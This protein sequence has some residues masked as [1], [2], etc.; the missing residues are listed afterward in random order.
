ML[1]TVHSLMGDDAQA[2]VNYR[3]AIEL[4]P[5]AR[6]YS[7][8]G[9]TYYRQ[10]RFAEAAPAYEQAARL[11]PSSPIKFRNLGDVYAR[12]GQRDRARQAYLRAVELSE[13]LLRVNPG[14]ARTLGLLAMSEAKL[15][16]HDA[17]AR[18]AEEASRLSPA[19]GEVL[20]RQAVVAALAGH[21]DQ[22]L[23]ALGQALARG[24]SATDAARDD[25]FGSLREKPTFH[26]LVIHPR[27]GAGK[28]GM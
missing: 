5:D 1:G 24:Y 18:H 17:A 13:S 25:D 19:D 20:Y 12:L 27:A 21:A 2:L 26:Q 3:R 28:G 14:D 4:S 23:A 7:N 10:G 16:R 6:A 11:E 15:G 22:S 8:L 9:T